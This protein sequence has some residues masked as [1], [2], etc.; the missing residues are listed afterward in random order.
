M[1]ELNAKDEPLVVL[2][3]V[4]PGDRGAAVA[5]AQRWQR[6]AELVRQETRQ[7][8]IA[9]RGFCSCC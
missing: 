8:F 7:T 2:V 9:V 5:E 4:L 1:V 3:V 6:V